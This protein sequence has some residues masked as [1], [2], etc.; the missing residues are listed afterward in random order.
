MPIDA[1]APLLMSCCRD[2]SPLCISHFGLEF[3]ADVITESVPQLFLG[4]DCIALLRSRNT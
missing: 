1:D 4:R 2:E 3:Y